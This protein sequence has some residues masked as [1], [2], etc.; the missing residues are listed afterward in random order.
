[1]VYIAPL[2]NLQGGRRVSR[3]LRRQG[4]A[5]QCEQSRGGGRDLEHSGNTGSLSF[6]GTG[7]A[8]SKQVEVSQKAKETGDPHWPAV[9]FWGMGVT[10]RLLNKKCLVAWIW[11]VL[12][13]AHG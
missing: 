3:K 2:L 4:Q 7:R 10:E 8:K 5:G 9:G 13:K 11:K 1:M 12:P 6:L